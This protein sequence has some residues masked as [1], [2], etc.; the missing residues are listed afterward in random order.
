LIQ[1]ANV[2]PSNISLGKRKVRKLNA[3]VSVPALKEGDRVKILTS[4]FGARY[5]EG[6]AKFT[7]GNIVSCKDGKVADVLWDGEGG[8]EPEIFES[9]LWHLQ[10]ASPVLNIVQRTLNK[11]IGNKWPLKN[12]EAMFP[13]LEVGSQLTETV[14]NSNGNWPKDFIEALIR[15]D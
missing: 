14:L 4:R 6:R 3:K 8:Y 11:A 10:R 13:I 1:G 2:D 12:V 15:P 9:R 7:Y 5:A